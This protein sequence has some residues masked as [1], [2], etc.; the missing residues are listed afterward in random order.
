[1]SSRPDPAEPIST[2]RCPVATVTQR[3]F[4]CQ[5]ISSHWI[6][7]PIMAALLWSGHSQA[8]EAQSPP[9]VYQN[10]GGEYIVISGGPAVR[11]WEDLRKPAEQHDRWWGNFIRP[12]RMRFEDLRKQYGPQAPI[13]W[14]VD[15]E[16]Y[17]RRSREEGRPLISYIESVRDRH[18]VRLIWFD[19]GQEVINYINRGQNRSSMKIAGLEF[20]G[21]SN[22]H[23]WMFDYS[24]DNLG[25]SR[26]W[27]HEQEFQKLRRSAFAN[28]AYV[29]S[30]GCHTAE[31]MSA[32]FRRQ[33]GVTMIGAIGKTDFTVLSQGILPIISDGGRWVY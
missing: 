12:A 5:R 1:M 25:V 17:V 2:A 26:S 31:S 29:R 24:N 14:L 9:R 19:S 23:C 21:H 33:T 3:T 7:F 6:L 20:F 11:R 28:K 8:Q 22:K 32:Y 16:G 10:L 18:Q 4:R 13:T 15:R 30:W 27:L